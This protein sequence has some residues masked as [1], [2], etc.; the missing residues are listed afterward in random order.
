VS[1]K[2]KHGKSWAGIHETTYEILASI[3]LVG[4]PYPKGDR[5]ILVELFVL[6]APC[7]KNDRK[8]F[9]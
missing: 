1:N 6:N 7:P 3:T 2:Q 8:R 9:Y 4:V 5:Y